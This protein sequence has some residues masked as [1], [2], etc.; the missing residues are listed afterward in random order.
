MIKSEPDDKV[1]SF[2]PV[3]GAL[4]LCEA[5]ADCVP[6]GGYEARSGLIIMEM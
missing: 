3:F 2:E 5:A 1:Y 4:W 6:G